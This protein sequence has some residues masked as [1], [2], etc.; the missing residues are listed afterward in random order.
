MSPSTLTIIEETTFSIQ[1]KTFPYFPLFIDESPSKYSRIV[2]Y[3]K[4]PSTVFS[5]VLK[6]FIK[7]HKIKSFERL[8]RKHYLDLFKYVL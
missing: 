1:H 7:L 8:L 6:C 2:V 3:N 4:H 5:N